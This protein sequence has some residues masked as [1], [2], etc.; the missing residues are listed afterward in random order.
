MTKLTD[1]QSILLTLGAQRPDGSLLPPSDTL[2]NK[3]S[4]VRKA[5]GQ[6]IKR[7]LAAEVEVTE[8]ALTWREEA[9]LRFGAVIT[10]AGKKAIDVQEPQV[11]KPVEPR[12]NEA[13][14]VSAPRA[15]SKQGKVFDMLKREQGASLDELVGATGWLPHTTRAALTGIR[16]RGVTLTKEKVSG[17]TRYKVATA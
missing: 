3:L 6:L 9:E 1:I 12:G 15:E 17:V 13:A 16:K 10:E 11:E 8:T 5:I 2:Q 4:P 14:A 7:G